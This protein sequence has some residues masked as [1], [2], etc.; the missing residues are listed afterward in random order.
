MR[1]RAEELTIASERNRRTLLRAP[2]D[3]V[4]QQVQ[5]HT[6]GAVVRPADAL[7]IVVP[8]G[9][10]LILEANV[11]NRDIG[12]MREG[13]DVRVKFEAFPFTRYGVI[14]GRLVF[15]SR[16]AVNDENLGLVFPSRVE[17][18]RTALSVDGRFAPISV[19]HGGERG[20]HDGQK[21]D[22]RVSALAAR[23]ARRRGKE[24]EVR[25]A[26]RPTFYY[27]WPNYNQ[28]LPERLD[29]TM[30][31]ADPKVGPFAA[32]HLERI[33][34]G[35][36]SFGSGFLRDAPPDR[37]VY[38]FDARC[39]LPDFLH[40][41]WWSISSAARD[42]LTRYAAG[43]IDLAPH[44]VFYRYKGEDR[45]AAP[46]W[47][48]D[49]IR[50]EDAVDPEASEIHWTPDGTQYDRN[51]KLVFKSVLPEGLHLFRIWHDPMAI[52]C[53]EE[54]RPAL[55]AAKLSGIVFEKVGGEP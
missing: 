6:I 25:M 55:R 53:S 17:L 21:A 2:A 18:S 26:K 1:L 43:A 36:R 8:D 42:V 54:L 11:L 44:E 28:R 15:V 3:G 35:Y 5:V 13:Q 22:H 38:A 37:S 10:R 40:G 16:D 48:C 52:V 29:S 34:E 47:L 50:F 4:V 19:R 32:P 30:A 20:D 12:F 41:N 31:R 7:M 24:G 27:I 23:T 49:V 33:G 39:P 9:A 45:P 46:R 51:S 14:D